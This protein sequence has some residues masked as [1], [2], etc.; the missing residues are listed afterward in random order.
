VGVLAPDGAVGFVSVLFENREP[1]RRAIAQ[2]PI[3]TS[4]FLRYVLQ[5]RCPAKVTR[6]RQWTRAGG[7]S[8]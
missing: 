2:P 6:P 4:P 1:V 8:G 5:Q 7:G 3:G